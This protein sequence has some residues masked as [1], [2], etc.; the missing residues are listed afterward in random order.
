MPR[1]PF[2]IVVIPFRVVGTQ[3]EYAIF[4]RADHAVWQWIAGGG[5]D[6][7]SPLAA[8]RR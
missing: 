7:E 4:R 6:S 8:A 5:E 2:Q 1:A 3:Y